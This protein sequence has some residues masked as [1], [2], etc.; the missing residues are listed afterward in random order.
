MSRRRK[1]RSSRAE[2]IFRFMDE[3]RRK[4]CLQQTF[5]LAPPA[6]WTAVTNAPVLTNGFY[7]ATMTP[8]NAS[9]F[10]RLI[11]ANEEN[12]SN[13]PADFPASGFAGGFIETVRSHRR[14]Y[15]TPF[16]TNGRR[17][18]ASISFLFRR[19]HQR[20]T[21]L[22]LTDVTNAA[23]FFLNV[24]PYAEYSNYFNVF[25]IFTNSAHS[26]STHLSYPMTY[27]NGYTYFNSTYDVTAI[28]SSQFR[29]IRPTAIPA[30]GRGKLTPCS[31]SFCLA[32][33]TILRTAGQ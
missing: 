20:Q 9:V 27:A 22:F 1:S 33:T 18:T 6:Q 31:S 5:N 7:V 28:M 3:Q 4:L 24:Q 2:Q 17:P 10:Y 16:S 14:K 32:Q 19:L 29:R 8:A 15:F 26:G 23:N 25:A 12:K 11:A 21:G 30:T 13:C